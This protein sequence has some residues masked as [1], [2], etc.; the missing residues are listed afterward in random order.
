VPV[1]QSF[2]EMKLLIYLLVITITGF[3]THNQE[4]IK[5]YKVRSIKDK[6]I[7]I[8]GKGDDPNWKFAN[9]LSNFIYPWEKER[10]PATSFRALQSDGWLY[11]LYVVKDENVQVLVKSN[12]K[13]EVIYSDRVEIFLRSD[14]RM[15]P[16]YGLE[17]DPNGRVFDYQAE[18]KGKFNENWSWP[19]GH[20]KVKANRVNDGYSV[21]VAISKESLIQLN[22][23]KG[24]RLEA[25]IFRGECIE[26]IEGKNSII[27]WISWVKPDSPTPNFHI[28]SSFGVL[29]LKD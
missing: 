6:Q 20:L 27:K 2:F 3:T 11:L 12:H 25:G 18:L 10:P 24:T 1:K 8:T 21:E 23:L 26:M 9:D 28:P 17:L 16:Y 5:T 22:L 4:K 19:S 15:A 7:A 29:D 14:D 13:S